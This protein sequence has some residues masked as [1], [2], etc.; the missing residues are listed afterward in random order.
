[1][2]RFRRSSL[3]TVVCGAIFVLATL[4]G[5]MFFAGFWRAGNTYRVSAYVTNAR[6]IAVNS[7]IF[8]AGLPVGQVTGV[9]RHGPDAILTLRIDKGV[10]PLPVDSKIQLGLRSLAGETDLLLAPGRSSERVRD[11]GS[12]GLSQNEPF[13]DVD[14]ILTELAGPTTTHA[15]EFF[16]GLGAGVDGEGRNLNQTI[17]GFASLVNES[18]PLT[19]TLAEQHQHVADIVENFGAIMDAITQRTAAMKQ[20]AR[21]GRVTFSAMA[22]RDAALKETLRWLPYVVKTNDD[23]VGKLGAAGPHINPLINHLA[24][25]MIKLKPTLDLLGPASVRGLAVLREL[26]AASPG[27]RRVLVGLEKLEPSATKALPALH[28][29]LCQVNPML[30]F[31]APYGNDIATFFQNFGAATDGYMEGPHHSHGLLTSALV[32][33]PHFYRGVNS[34]PLDDALT[35][36]F[37]SGLMRPV[38]QKKFGYHALVPHGHIGDPNI[39]TGMRG[40]IEW[41]A[42]NKFPHVVADCEK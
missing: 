11:G 10:K 16:Q 20:F 39:G 38:D 34:R 3:V 25:T 1:M 21:G 22:S 29:T 32:D 4:L 14:E 33:P 12:L 36:L 30:R 15:R 42:Q 18:P 23:V 6:G 17:G 9:K 35:V 7:T 19:S 2:I 13:T 5:L 24:S 40:P 8:E 28:S 41:G 27:L 26:G 37:N 31:L